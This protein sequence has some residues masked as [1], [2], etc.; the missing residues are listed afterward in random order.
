MINSFNIYRFPG[1]ATVAPATLAPTAFVGSSPASTPL[2]CFSSQATALVQHVGDVPLQKLQVGDKIMTANGYQTFYGFVHENHDATEDFLQIH[3]KQQQ[4]PLEISAQHMVFVQGKSSPIPAQLIRPGDV[5]QSHMS[6]PGLEVKKVVTVQR[7]GFYAPLTTDGTVVVDG[8]VSSCYVGL[9]EDEDMKFQGGLRTG[10]S[11]HSM[12]HLVM[13]P[14]RM[15]C[16][17][18]TPALCQIHD[19][20]GLLVYTKLCWALAEFI[21]NRWLPVQMVLFVL[22]LLVLGTFY[23][24]EWL[25][26]PT[27]GMV[28]ILCLCAAGVRKLRSAFQSTSANSQMRQSKSD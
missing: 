1:A 14:I 28:V 15:A 11:Q 13:T 7:K 27:I 12:A 5:L 19:D 8:V 10:L 4:Q 3:T 22:C 18:V 26:G 17:G 2:I 25:V 16:L 20:F 23:V 24:L 6:S 9:Q 21:D